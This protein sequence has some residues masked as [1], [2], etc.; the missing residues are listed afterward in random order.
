MNAL[1][2]LRADHRNVEALFDRFAS[3]RT[4]KRQMDVF[5]EIKA[6]LD[7]HAA[8]EEE[9]FYPAVRNAA[10]RQG[11]VIEKA[12]G[13]H[14]L[15]KTLLRQLATRRSVDDAFEGRMEVLRENVEHHVAE[16]ET[17][18]FA[19]ARR[20]LDARELGSLAAEIERHRESLRGG[21][22]LGVVTGI[23]EGTQAM[24]EREQDMMDRATNAMRRA[25][26]PSPKRR[27]AARTSAKKT[28]AKKQ[29]RRPTARSTR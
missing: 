17:T 16:E 15:A 29:S 7:A 27:A 12:L 6:A 14:E 24:I 19:L 28:S 1:N 5:G 9:I 8:A 3:A 21:G 20:H 10:K 25:M 4:G 2:L 11:V 13:E 23:A 22:V 18:L 26:N